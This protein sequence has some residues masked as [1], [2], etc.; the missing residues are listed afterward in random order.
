MSAARRFRWTR[1]G[2]PDVESAVEGRVLW[3]KPGLRRG[4]LVSDAGERIPF[5]VNGDDSGIHGGAR[6]ACR[7]TGV[8]GCR[9][10]VDCIVLRSCQDA[11]AAEAGPL[12]CEFRSLLA[13]G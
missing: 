11:V 9:V 5:I 4:C 12:L 7:V 8:N 10:A 6:I 13:Q 3:Y 1:I 2:G